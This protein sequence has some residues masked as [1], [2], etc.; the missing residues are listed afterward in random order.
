MHRGLAE[1]LAP[2][3]A[4]LQSAT[5]E[6]ARRIHSCELGDQ[7]LQCDPS[8]AND[9]DIHGIVLA[10]LG[11]VDVDLD[12]GL[13]RLECRIPTVSGELVKRHAYG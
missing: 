11:R 4:R 2:R 3:F 7:C 6:R 12:E 8:V 9:G 5:R 13:R 10:E 1:V